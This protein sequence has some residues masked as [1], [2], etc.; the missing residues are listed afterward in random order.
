MT[1]SGCCAWEVSEVYTEV[2]KQI[3]IVPINCIKFGVSSRH[4]A[5]WYGEPQAWKGG[6]EFGNRLVNGI[7]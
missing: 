7:R 3:R 1:G 2:S 6:Q 4:R 5:C